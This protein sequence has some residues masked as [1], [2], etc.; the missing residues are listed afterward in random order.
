LNPTVA[1]L[2]LLL[3]SFA[4]DT[5]QERQSL[6][7]FLFIRH[8]LTLNQKP[9]SRHDALKINYVYLWLIVV[10]PMITNDYLWYNIRLSPMVAYG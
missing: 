2:I 6:L 5:L 4:F 7:H 3:F 10:N 9:F 1:A 8:P